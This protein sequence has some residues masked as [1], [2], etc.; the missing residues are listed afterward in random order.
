MSSEVRPFFQSVPVQP[1][2]SAAVLNPNVLTPAD[3][4][5]ESA[6]RET[7]LN[8]FSRQRYTKAS[9]FK[10]C[11]FVSDYELFLT[12]CNRPRDSWGFFILAWLGSEEAEKTRRSYITDH[13]ANNPV[14]R[15]GLISLFGRFEF[16]GAYRAAVRS[17]RQS[18]SESVAA[19]AARVT[20]LCSRTY[21]N[22]S[23]DDQLSL[24][25]D[26][27]ISG[28]ADTLSRDYLMRE[29]ARRPLQW[30]EVVRMAQASK[31]ARLSEPVHSNA[32][33]MLLRASSNSGGA[34]AST[35]PVNTAPRGSA[36]NRKKLDADSPRSRQPRTDHD[37]EKQ[38]RPLPRQEYSNSCD[39]AT[40][41]EPPPYEKTSNAMA[42]SKPDHDS[43]RDNAL[44]LSVICFK[45][46]KQ[47]HISS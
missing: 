40:P 20:D 43:N 9:G 14:F 31:A 15:E 29:R 4:V 11:S 6:D 37:S 36:R 33:A 26:H 25:V 21:L 17:L 28:I 44:S 41:R 19:Y 35:I 39:Q 13:V 12:F 8:A 47:S 18:G 38:S 10:I 1:Q 27:F 42:T 5:W 34:I 23:T 22:F 3:I 24:A 46:G 7:L 32:A 16:E 45:C 2:A 30:Q